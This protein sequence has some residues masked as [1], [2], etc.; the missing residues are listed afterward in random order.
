MIYPTTLDRAPWD[1][2]RASLHSAVHRIPTKKPCLKRPFHIY[3][4]TTNT[5]YPYK[6]LS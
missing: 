4:A 1:T 5:H 3:T 6:A 2:L